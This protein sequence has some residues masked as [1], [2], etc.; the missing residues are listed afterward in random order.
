MNISFARYLDTVSSL[1]IF[2]YTLL[3]LVAGQRLIYSRDTEKSTKSDDKALLV[4]SSGYMRI[5]ELVY[6]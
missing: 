1:E 2:Q 5:E 4:K 6:E 3:S